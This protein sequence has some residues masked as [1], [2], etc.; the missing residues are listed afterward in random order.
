M[1]VGSY[2]DIQ[3]PENK[4]AN[5]RGDGTPLGE[6]NQQHSG[7]PLS[8]GISLT[9]N[10]T[11]AL[12]V[13]PLS[14]SGLW[15]SGPAGSS[16]GTSYSR[17]DLGT[18][19][20]YRA[21]ENLGLGFGLLGRQTVFNNLSSSHFIRSFLPQAKLTSFVG[22]YTASLVY[23]KSAYSALGYT[24]DHTWNGQFFKKSETH[25][26]FLDF[27]VSMLLSEEAALSLAATQEQI[28]TTI[29]DVNEYNS[30]GLSVLDPSH[31]SRY[32]ELRTTTFTVGITKPL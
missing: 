21:S 6:E 13:S 18:H 28:Q 19:S 25:V 3:V 26:T 22:N 1:G 31:P 8:M 20:F 5:T 23:A 15:I 9:Y 2:Q 30:F 4:V 16:G 11:P 14:A 24:Q 32:Y 12:S 7:I 27:A 10:L 17:L 29:P